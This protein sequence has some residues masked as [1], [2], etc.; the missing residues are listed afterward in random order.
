MRKPIEEFFLWK[1]FVAVNRGLLLLCCL[2]AVGTIAA[3]VLMRYVFKSDLYGLEEIVTLATMWLYFMGGVDGSYEDS[4]IDADVL[5]LF[6]KSDKVKRIFKI[7][8]KVVCLVVSIVFAKWGLDYLKWA[9]AVGGMTQT[10]RIPMLL[11]RIPLSIAFILMVIFN[12]YHLVNAILGRTPPKPGAA[13]KK[14]EEE[15][16]NA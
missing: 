2:I 8:I 16:E 7:F 14:D 4:H 3:S 12:I 10:L 6:V 1:A 13:K 5:S 9:A 11:S 15:A